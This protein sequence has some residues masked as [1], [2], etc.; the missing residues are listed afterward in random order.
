MRNQY[1]QQ[2]KHLKAMKVWS[3]RKSVFDQ[4]KA[5]LD[6]L[7]GRQGS[8]DSTID[9]GLDC[10]DISATLCVGLQ[11]GEKLV[12]KATIGWQIPGSCFKGLKSLIENNIY[13]TFQVCLGTPFGFIKGVLSMFG[14]DC[15][16]LFTIRVYLTLNMVAVEVGKEIG[17]V[18]GKITGSAG[19]GPLASS[20]VSDYCYSINGGKRTCNRRKCNQVRVCNAI[21]IFWSVI[22]ICTMKNGNSCHTEYYRCAGN[23]GGYNNCIQGYNDKRKPQ[24]QFKKELWVPWIR[25]NRRR[26]WLGSVSAGGSW[27]TTWSHTIKA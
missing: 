17:P 21:R 16:T 25:Y 10:F 23:Q 5:A 27:K 13:L 11:P 24:I 22:N 7:G 3:G 18:K 20:L 6:Y 1:A 9:T 26:R 2:S 14:L 8:G 4:A 19:V 12:F 15:F